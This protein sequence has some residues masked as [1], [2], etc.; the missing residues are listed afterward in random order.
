MNVPTDLV[1]IDKYGLLGSNFYWYK[2]ETHGLTKQDIIDAGLTNDRVQ[3]S[4]RIINILVE[5]DCELQSENR[6]LYI[7]E[8]YRSETLY[9]M[10]Y[11]RRVEKYG[12]DIT[13]TIL[14]MEA[15]PHAEGLTVDATLWDLKEDK[16][17][18][19]RRPED[20]TAALFVGFY[21][22]KKDLE[23]QQYQDLQD[24]LIKLMM[25]YG[26][27][28]GSKREYFHFDYRSNMP[29]NYE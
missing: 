13:D 27:R 4:K 24:Y 11:K 17:I 3:V 12:K 6:R 16:E 28:L 15:M 9:N 25:R 2:Y 8:G 29:E 22:D 20:G 19:L 14:N 1:Y 5:I 10:V 7:K 21:K 26:F 18:Y 23:L